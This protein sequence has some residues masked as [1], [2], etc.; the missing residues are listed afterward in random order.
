MLNGQDI[1]PRRWGNIPIGVQAVGFGYAYS[2]GDVLFDPLLEA[3]AVE[4]DVHTLV[5]S[6]VHPIKLGKKYA[7]LDVLF[8]VSFARWEGLLSGAPASAERNGMADPRV[9]FSIHLLGPPA[10]G[11]AALKIPC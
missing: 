7:R 10:L 9:R 3:E 6:F 5:G 2:F 4:V 1:E 11:P 8:P